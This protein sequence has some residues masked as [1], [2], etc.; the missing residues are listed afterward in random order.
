MKAG[1]PKFFRDQAAFRKWLEQHHASATEIWVG[2]YKTR[3]GKPSITAPQAVD[4]ALCFGWIDGIRKSIDEDAYTNRFTPRRKGSNW[5]A[6]NIRR[7]G[8]LIEQGLMTP[9]GLAAY[10][11]RDEK[12]AAQY[13]FEQHNV[14]MPAAYVQ[15]FKKAKKAWAFWVRQPPSYRRTI[16]WWVTS[17]K[18]EATRQRRLQKLIGKCAAGER[19]GPARKK[20]R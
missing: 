18:Q 8:E 11:L 12:K 2:F 7:A 1:T 16:T 9:A 4:Q 5:S 13:S 20:K 15:Q 6:I 19:V 14:S 10:R 17:A 3:T